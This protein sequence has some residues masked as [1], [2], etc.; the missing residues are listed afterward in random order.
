MKVF[1]EE[2]K[3]RLFDSPLYRS[4]KLHMGLE[5]KPALS[6]APMNQKDF[7]SLQKFKAES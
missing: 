7:A 3:W 4:L 5:N 6:K 1:S 2:P